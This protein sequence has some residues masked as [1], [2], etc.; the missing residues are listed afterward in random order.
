M[1]TVFTWKKRLIVDKMT[2]E[3]TPFV[4]FVCYFYK[5][6]FVVNAIIFC[7]YWAIYL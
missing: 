2:L 7:S 3:R 6:L 5:K 4:A 1:I